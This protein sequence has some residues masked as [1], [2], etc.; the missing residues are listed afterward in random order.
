MNDNR[1]P[2]LAATLWPQQAASRLARFAALA[3][4][5]GRTPEQGIQLAIQ[6]MLV[7]PH[8]LFHIEHDSN[9]TD[10]NAAHKISDIELANRLSYFLWSSMPDE[11]LQALAETGKLSQSAV[12]DAQ[13]KRM[14]ADP[15][16]SAMAENFA[17]QWPTWPTR[18]LAS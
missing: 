8:F 5:D 10:P 14:L 7:S 15:K 3:K 18:S 6:A 1:R 13:V 4:A 17:G 9:P 2:T 11:E 12:M 16:A